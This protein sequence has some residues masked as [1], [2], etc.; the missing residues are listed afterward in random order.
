MRQGQSLYKNPYRWFEMDIHQDWFLLS[1]G[2]S[3]I[4][5][6][7]YWLTNRGGLDR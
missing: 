4:V 5:A 2:L 3:T 7:Y 6:A 1:K